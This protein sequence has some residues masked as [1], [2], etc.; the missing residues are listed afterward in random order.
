MWGLKKNKGSEVKLGLLVSALWKGSLPL[1]CKTLLFWV[2]AEVALQLL[3]NCFKVFLRTFI[4][5]NADFKSYLNW[6]L[7]RPLQ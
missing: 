2:A 4:T 5:V 3:A 6:G 7:I 1:C